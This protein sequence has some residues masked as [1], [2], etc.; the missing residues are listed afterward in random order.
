LGRLKRDVVIARQAFE[1]FHFDQRDLAVGTIFGRKSP[2][3]EKIAVANQ[4]PAGH[5]FDLVDRL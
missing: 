3:L 1:R 2:D 4:S 5:R